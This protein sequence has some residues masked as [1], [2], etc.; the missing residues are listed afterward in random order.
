MNAATVAL[1]MNACPDGGGGARG[2]RDARD[3]E[4]VAELRP[5]ERLRA[6]GEASLSD[7]QLVALVLR[8]GVRGAPVGRIA[9]RLLERFEGLCG[10]E[11]AGL[12]ELCEVEGV[13]LAAAC[14][15]KA[16]LALGRRAAQARRER[17][18][19]FRNSLDVAR[20]YG[21]ALGGLETEAFHALVLDARHRR[22]RDV[23]IASG[24]VSSCPVR[25]AE[26]FA[27]AVREAARA[28]VFAHN[29]PSGDPTPS[30]DDRQLTERLVEAGAF[31]GID[32]LD[33]IVVCAG[34]AFFSF[35]DEK[36]L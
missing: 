31:L 12:A 20:Y 28:V 24:T 2:V 26:A 5:R 7:A 11:R 9:A 29:H 4:G 1:G 34:D 30:A 8:T 35:A 15:L 3:G 18:D 13:G 17:G 21:P 16:A 19:V 32:V 23:R 25:P 36:Q 27:P 14:E 33:H 6:H 22:I 10:L